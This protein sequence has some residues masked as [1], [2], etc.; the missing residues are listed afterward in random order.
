[1]FLN[2]DITVS[3]YQYGILVLDLIWMAFAVIAFIDTLVSRV[4]AGNWYNFYLYKHIQDK[5]WY[6][7][8]VDCIAEWY[9]MITIIQV[10]AVGFTNASRRNLAFQNQHISKLHQKNPDF[11]CEPGAKQ[12]WIDNGSCCIWQSSLPKHCRYVYWK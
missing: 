11:F 8:F 1:M 12:G 4:L 6:P 5:V 2:N 7:S 9:C 3:Q 10:H